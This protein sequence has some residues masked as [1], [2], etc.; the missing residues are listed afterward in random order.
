MRPMLPTAVI[1]PA[2][3][4]AE[5]LPGTLAGSGTRLGGTAMSRQKWQAM[6]APSPAP[7]NTGSSTLQRG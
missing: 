1:I 3:N 7:S 2:F 6:R 5:A 4:E